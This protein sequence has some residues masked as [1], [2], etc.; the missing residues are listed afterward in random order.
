MLGSGR[1]QTL[2]FDTI[3]CYTYVPGVSLVAPPD[4]GYNWE[5]AAYVFILG[6]TKHW[7]G[8]QVTEDV[9]RAIPS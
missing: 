5:E 8:F 6:G 9:V 2:F 3:S 4:E 1:P 7:A